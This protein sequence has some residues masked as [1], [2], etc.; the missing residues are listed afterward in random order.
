MKMAVDTS[1]NQVIDLLQ[2]LEANT[3]V[4]EQSTNPHLGKNID[5]RL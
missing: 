3:K 1:E 5:S 4:M 2:V